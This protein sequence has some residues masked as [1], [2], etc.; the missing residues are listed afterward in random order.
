MILVYFFKGNN[1]IALLLVS[2]IVAFFHETDTE[3][4]V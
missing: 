4:N 2:F 3:K 1:A